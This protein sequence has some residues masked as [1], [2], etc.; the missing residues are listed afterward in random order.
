MSWLS[1]FVKLFE[2]F[3]AW[4]SENETKFQVIKILPWHEYLLAIH[5]AFDIV[6][7]L[8]KLD[9]KFH[10]WLSV[11]HELTLISQEIFRQFQYLKIHLI[12]NMYIELVIKPR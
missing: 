9:K 2:P 5:I 4:M 3:M 6:Y 12:Y 11:I 7:H 10:E 8:Q 1:Q